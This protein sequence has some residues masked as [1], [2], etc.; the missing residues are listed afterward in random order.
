MF[1]TTTCPS[2][3]SPSHLLA[4]QNPMTIP[5]QTKELLLELQKRIPPEKR[6]AFV[7]SVN[8]R[9]GELVTKNTVYYTL[10][11]GLIGHLIGHVPLVGY[12]SEHHQ[13]E[14]DMALRAWVGIA[15]DQEERKRRG[16][17]ESII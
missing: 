3:L 12:F 13:T 9:L 10:L 16:T 6:D 8:A 7:S 15:K 17:T 4:P 2:S 14:I 1:R 5:T 11:G